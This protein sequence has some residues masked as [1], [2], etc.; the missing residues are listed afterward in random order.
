MDGALM[1][2]ELIAPRVAD[3]SERAP[4]ILIVRLSAIGD[5]I[6]GLPALCALREAM[7]NAFLGWIAEGTAGDVLDGH[8]ALD[9]LIRVPRRYWKSPGE[10]WKMRRRLRALKFDVAIDLQCLT[11]SAL[12]A[13]LSGAPRRIGKSGE[14]G[15]ELSRFI[16]NELVEAGGTH[17][18]EHYLCMLS[19][20]GIANPAPR[21]DLPERPVDANYADGFLREC[22]LAGQRF[23]VLNPGAGWPSKMWPAERYGELAQHLFRTHGIRSIAAWGIPPEQPLA[24][25]IV[26]ASDGHALLAPKTSMLEF[27]ALCRRAALF[28]GSDTGPMHLSVAV[29]TPTLSMHGPSRAD[30]CGAYGPTNVRMQIRYEAGSSLERRR[31]DDSAMRAITVPMVSHACDRLLTLHAARKCG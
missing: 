19:T 10:V 4:R 28:V 22:G 3:T 13:W 30:W 24:E 2:N 21:F 7:P 31:A 16:N 15:R 1:S 25:T 14:H 27:G 26:A 5:V 20:L 6:H 9:E 23:A 29:G 12:T 18:I 17:V 8:P 11:K